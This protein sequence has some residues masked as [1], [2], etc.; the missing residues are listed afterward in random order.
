MNSEINQLDGWVSKHEDFV[1]NFI[2]YICCNNTQVIP[3]WK[4]FFYNVA[5]KVE[6]THVVGYLPTIPKSPTSMDTVQEVLRLCKEKAESLNLTETDLVLDHAIYSKAVEIIM[7]SRNADLRDFINLRMGGF[8]AVCIFMGVIGKRFSE[9]GLKD[10][11]V[12]SGLM[13]EDSARQTLNG[14]H[15]NNAM[16]THLYVA[17]AITRLK[18]DAF[19]DWLAEKNQLS[20]Y[21][22]IVNNKALVD[23]Q[24]AQNPAN[25]KRS[26]CVLE[27][28][29]TLYDKF[30]TTLLGQDEYPMAIFWNSYLNMVQILRDFSKSIKNGDWDL[31][32]YASEKMLHWFNAYDHYNYAR[33]FSYY[34]ASQQVLAETHPGIFN[35]FKEG[36]FSIRRSN[37]KFNKIS[38][39]QVIEQTINRDQKGPGKNYGHSPT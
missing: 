13:G 7:L 29:F 34:W 2:R 39:D 11:I 23:L 33:H 15:Y 28:L 6:N 37:G 21:T 5:E 35:Q 16:R 3:G 25:F 20:K 12:E 10:L 8:H 18:L 24:T 1:W 4:G 17:E 27:E 31:H 38:P 14:K 9:A 22:I 30:E 32:M 36:N 26:M 19:K